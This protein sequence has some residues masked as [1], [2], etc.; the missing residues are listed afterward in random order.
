[1][2]RISCKKYINEYKLIRTQIDTSHA[3]I[4][5]AFLNTANWSEQRMKE[6]IL[7][8]RKRPI[9]TYKLEN[10]IRVTVLSSGAVMGGAGNVTHIDIGVGK[11][12]ELPKH[13][14]VLNSG[15]LWNTA[16]PYIPFYGKKV[17]LGGFSPGEER[18]SSEH[19]REGQWQVG[20]AKHTFQAKK[21]IEGTHY[22]DI[23]RN[24]AFHKLTM[25]VRDFIQQAQNQAI[26]SAKEVK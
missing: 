25:E 7:S 16:R 5:E 3:L 21:A 23:T 17:P 11:I 2:L 24:E 14:A 9:M 1:M 6:I 15:F 8:K 20:M 26:A 18:P 13:W 12:S 19:S 22:I 4:Q 10:A